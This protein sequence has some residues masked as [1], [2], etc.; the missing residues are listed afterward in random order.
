MHDGHNFTLVPVVKTIL[1]YYPVK[2]LACHPFI[3][4]GEVAMTRQLLT[5]PSLMKGWIA[6]QDGV[7]E[8]LQN[9]TVGKQVLEQVNH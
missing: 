5:S 3:N 8:I 7:V 4:E 1:S 9:V 6:K 2:P